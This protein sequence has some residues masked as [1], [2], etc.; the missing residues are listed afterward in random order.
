MGKKMLLFAFSSIFILFVDAALQYDAY[1]EICAG[2]EKVVLGET[3]RIIF[4]H[5]N[6]T[7]QLLR[8]LFHDCFV[9]GCDASV[10]LDDS[11]GTANQST[12]RRALPNKTLR[13]FNHINQIKEVVENECP[14]VV[15]C[16][17]ILALAT[18]D[19]IALLGGPYFPVLTGRKDSN[20]SLYD[21]A[22]EGIPRP[23][24]S[25]SETLLLFAQHGFNARE[26]VA[27]LGGHSI[28]RIG[29]EFIQSRLNR[30]DG[31]VPLDFQHEIKKKCQ[32]KD[33]NGSV[34]ILDLRGKSRILTEEEDMQYYQG[35]NAVENPQGGGGFDSH[36]YQAL[37]VGRGLLTADQELMANEETAKAVLDYAD[38]A[39]LF[40]IEFAVAMIKLSN[41]NV[42]IG[43]DGEV[44][45]HCSIV[46]SLFFSSSSSSWFSSSP[47]P[48]PSP[49]SSS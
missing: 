45:R 35:L 9:E 46:N 18:R 10:L 20:H 11:N 7:A 26:T 32:E 49:S 27:L 24:S 23:D 48:S 3:K 19:A 5:E 39:K 17:D 44:R 28:G 21:K 30:T 41:L 2:A 42:R 25:I 1:R 47:S 31:S 16:A 6:A 29:C 22:L 13:G 37:K 8:L 14:G 43:S 15:S 34:S 38:D 36:Y 33:G 12:E 4:E 40:R